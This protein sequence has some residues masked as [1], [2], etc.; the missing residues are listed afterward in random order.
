METGPPPEVASDDEDGAS[1][2]EYGLLLAG[3]AAT[4]AAAVLAFGPGVSNLFTDTCDELAAQSTITAT[5]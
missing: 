1:A 4:V 5:C 2:V 3:I